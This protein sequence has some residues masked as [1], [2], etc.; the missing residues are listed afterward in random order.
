MF[1]F[2][3]KWT[4]LFNYLRIRD[5]SWPTNSHSHGH[6]HG[7]FKNIGHGHGPWPWQPWITGVTQDTSW[8]QQTTSLQHKN[9]S[10]RLIIPIHFMQKSR[11]HERTFFT[12]FRKVFDAI[13][14]V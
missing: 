9:V 14:F 5:Y 2:N 10:S 12:S 11:F 8:Y 6:G 4:K 3:K 7:F 1:Q 13:K